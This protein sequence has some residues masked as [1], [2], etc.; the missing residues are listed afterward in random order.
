M[1]A[2]IRDVGQFIRLLNSGDL[3][4]SDEQAIY[5]SLYVYNHTGLLPGYQSIAPLF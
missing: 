4:Q 5:S 3:F 2:N 1:I